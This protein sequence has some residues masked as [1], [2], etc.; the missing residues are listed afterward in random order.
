MPSVQG[1]IDLELAGMLPL[2]VPFMSYLFLNPVRSCSNAA[3][4]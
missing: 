2:R 4:P 1:K 3:V